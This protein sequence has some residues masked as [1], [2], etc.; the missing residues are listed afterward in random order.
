[1]GIMLERTM[2]PLTEISGVKSVTLFESDGFVVYR[3]HEDMTNH[4]KQINRWI[5]AL[6]ASPKSNQVTFILEEGTV[7][8]RRGERLHLTVNCE[9]STN[10]GEVR[11]TA[12]SCHHLL[13]NTT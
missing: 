7:I 1:M 3:S 13:H 4:D 9:S 11:K 2:A 10:L 12:E 6:D 5:S 8:L